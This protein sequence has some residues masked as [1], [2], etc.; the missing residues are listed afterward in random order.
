MVFVHFAAL[1]LTAVIAEYIYEYSGVD[2]D[3]FRAIAAPMLGILLVVL[4]TYWVRKVAQQPMAV[5]GRSTRPFVDVV[6]GVGVGFGA[7][8][9]AG[10]ATQATDWFLPAP[11]S[12]SPLS[13]DLR[14][15]A[16]ALVIFAVVVCAPLGEELFF[17]A[18]LMGG[19]RRRM[20]AIPAIAISSLAFAMAHISVSRFPAIFVIGAVFGW[21]YER[22]R[23]ILPT[24]VG[25]ATVNTLAV[26]VYLSQLHR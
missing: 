13:G 23:S 11:R 12:D 19:L 4:V 6:M 5:L 10:L 24:I 9:L 1:G 17:R 21:A 15:W 18:F 25:H 8:F 7:V 20:R 3:A 16:G 26:V 2:K 14:G 22:R